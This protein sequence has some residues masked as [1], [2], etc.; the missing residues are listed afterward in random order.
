MVGQDGV[1]LETYTDED[2]QYLFRDL[3]EKDGIVM[4]QYF[5]DHPEN[6]NGTGNCN[7]NG[8]GRK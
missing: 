1:S 2:G 6:V 7:Y 3:T 4:N 8:K 5:A